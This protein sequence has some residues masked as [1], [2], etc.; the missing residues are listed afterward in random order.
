[1]MQSS[2]V[3]RGRLRRNADP[4]DITVE[5]GTIRA[6]ALPAP[7]AD[8]LALGGTD[9]L[10]AEGFFDIHVNGFAGVDFNRPTLTTSELRRAAEAMWRT[11]VTQFLPT[12][13]TASVP[14][15]LGT[16][17]GLAAAREGDPAL[18]Q[19]IPGIHLEGPFLA[20]EDGPRGSHPAP[21]IQ[22]PDWELIEKLQDAARGLIRLVTLAPERPGAIGLIWQL[23]QAGMAV[24]IGHTA[25]DEA[26]ID[27]AV[28]AGAQLSGHL[29][30]GAHAML[31]RHR[32]YVQKQLAT[33]EL[34]ASLI[35]D[36][37]HLPSYVVKNMVRCKGADRIIL[38]TDA[39]AAAAAP[40]GR[41]RLGEV[42]AEVGSDGYVRLPGTPYLAGSAL[43]MDRAVRNVMEFAGVPLD[44]ALHCAARHPRRLVTGLGEG[45]AI[46]QPANLTLLRP[47]PPL[48]VEATIVAGEVVYR[49]DGASSA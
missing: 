38:I 34:V 26:D 36:G 20:P 24:S 30:N 21:Y 46:G 8:R 12:V 25:A 32:N 40:P 9:C 39:M 33:D 18:R 7:R 4:M 47:G 45:V 31:P 42:L 14:D 13:I 22:D 35:V 27:R 28:Q 3:I 29:G 11:G 17:K 48:T 37:H 43:T 19:S 5:A 49:R 44:D 10:V 23:R 16:L 6:I 41:Y 2:L 15:M 1:M